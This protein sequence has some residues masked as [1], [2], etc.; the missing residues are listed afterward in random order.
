MA[1]ASDLQQLYIGYF[2]RA[3][4]QTGLDFWVNAINNGGLSLDNVRASFVQSAEYSAKYTGLTSDALVAQVYLN[5]LG[6]PAEAEGK[7]FWANAL[8]TGAITQDKLIEGLLSGLSAGDQAIINNKVTV[9]NFYTAQRGADFNASDIGNSALIIAPVNGSTATVSTALNTI[10]TTVPA[11]AAANGPVASALNVYLAA[12]KAA[13]DSAKTVIDPVTKVAVVDGNANGSVVDEA[14]TILT[15]AQGTAFGTADIKVGA[16]SS[17]DLEV[18]DAASVTAAK[19]SEATTQAAAAVTAAQAAVDAKP[20]LNAAATSF[21]AAKANF[22]AA[23]A[24][25]TAA[26]NEYLAENAKFAVFDGAITTPATAATL[27]AA[28]GVVA[29]LT[30]VD[31]ATGNL[32][33]EAAYATPAKTA[34]QVAAANELLADIKALLAADKAQIAANT[35][36]DNAA[37]AVTTLDAANIYDTGT[38]AFTAGL[39]FNLQ[40]EKTQQTE[41]AKAI[42]DLAAA[43]SALKQLADLNSAKTAA[44][45]AVDK[46]LAGGLVIADGS[47]AGNGAQAELFIAKANDAVLFEK[48]DFLY[49]GAGFAKGVDADAVAGGIQGG[50]DSALEVFFQTVGADTNVVIEKTVFGSSAVVPEVITITLTGVTADKLAFDAGTGLV[51]VA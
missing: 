2:G 27:V 25:A 18:T 4:D 50:N 9:A 48:G 44:D 47:A 12:A 5:V 35:A 40:T 41:L 24:A 34:V 10:V 21:V 28:N 17:V 23:A 19:L 11:S 51:S 39:V 32:V 13:E 1:T 3:A 29:G 36:V 26:G 43:D 22:D 8:N 49:V 14:T 7:A 16:A 33:L 30:K 20:G 45:T 38:N 6:R 37:A 15:A 46:V 31:V 42:S